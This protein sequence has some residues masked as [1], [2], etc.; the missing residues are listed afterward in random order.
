MVIEESKKSAPSAKPASKR[1][2]AASGGRKR[3]I[4]GGSSGEGT[5]PAVPLPEDVEIP[6]DEDDA[7]PEGTSVPSG[8]KAFL[9]KFAMDITE[10][11]GETLGS[12]MSSLELHVSREIAGVSTS[13]EGALTSMTNRLDAHEA[14]TQTQ[15]NDLKDKIK[16][17]ESRCDRSTAALSAHPTAASSGGPA[18]MRAPPVALI[19]PAAAVATHTADEKEIVLIAGFPQ[20]MP[21]VV[22]QDYATEALSLLPE[23][24]RRS[25]KTRLS[26]AD[27]KF[28]FVFGSAADAAEFVAIFSSKDVYYEDPDD[29]TRT[30]LRAR[31]GRPLAL[32]RRG[33]ATHPI[34]GKLREIMDKDASTASMA[35]VQQSYPKNGTWNTDFYGQLGHKLVPFF[36]ASFC[37]GPHSTTVSEI[38]LTKNS[39]LSSPDLASLRDAAKI[40]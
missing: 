21:K 27:N 30:P 8:L 17:I 31:Q 38:A 26:P 15:F 18:A 9:D 33:A 11:I 14:A 6:D 10:K 20:V 12:R 39:K 40:V 22:L 1:Y 19:P 13:L 36:T 7:M 32:R 4:S 28:S 24:R 25:V 23:E 16:D 35:I 29:Q 34:Y 2:Q 3:P 37:E 5:P